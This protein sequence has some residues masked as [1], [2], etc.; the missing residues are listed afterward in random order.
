M[1]EAGTVGFG[2]GVVAAVAFGVRRVQLS[3]NPLALPLSSP[4]EV[5]IKPSSVLRHPK[6]LVCSCDSFLCLLG[7]VSRPCVM[8]KNRLFAVWGQNEGGLRKGWQL[9]Q[10]CMA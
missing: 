8:G 2:A 9:T 1:H 5:K 4:A 10:T 3:C 7:S 6:D